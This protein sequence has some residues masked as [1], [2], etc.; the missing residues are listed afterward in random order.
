LA[1]HGVAA[2]LNLAAGLNYP[3]P[4]GVTNATEFRNAIRNAYLTKTFE[5]LATQLADA[6]NQTCPFR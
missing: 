6:N 5:P 3:L 2:L 4:L 1:R